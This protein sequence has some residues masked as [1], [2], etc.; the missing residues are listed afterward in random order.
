MGV[1]LLLLWL[2]AALE[3]LLVFVV[4]VAVV[5]LVLEVGVGVGDGALS[6]GFLTFLLLGV[7]ALGSSCFVRLPLEFCKC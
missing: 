6:S 3:V 7:T 2:L 1:L 5:V 4:F